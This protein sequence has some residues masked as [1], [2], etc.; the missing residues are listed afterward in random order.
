MTEGTTRASLLTR[1]AATFGV[2]F[3]MLGFSVHAA[4]RFADF[5]VLHLG[6]DLARAARWNDAY[7][8]EAFAAIA[9]ARPEMAA[10]HRELDVFL[11]TPA[12]GWAMW[13]FSA[14]PVQSA[15]IVWIAV[16]V[17]AVAIATRVLSLPLWVVAIA[18]VM[19]FG[20]ANLHHGQTG[21]FA[22]L[23]ATGVH[24]LCVRDRKVL[25]GL[26]AG[27]V[28]LKPTLLLGVAIWWLIDWR[29][30]YPAL[31]AAIPSALLLTLPGLVR[32]GLEPWRL[33]AQ[34][35]SNRI[36]VQSDVVANQPTIRELLKRLLGGDIG[37]HPAMQLLILASGAA[38]MLAL[39][40]RFADRTDVMSGAAVFV[41]ILVSPHLYVYDSGLV[42]I[43]L[44]VLVHHNAD[45]WTTERL[46]A[47]YTMS[48]LL[49][50]MS[51]GFFGTFNEWVA[52]G[53]I[54]ILAM[55]ALWIRTIHRAD[56]SASVR[57][58]RST[59]SSV[60]QVNVTSS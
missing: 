48:S 28:V 26:T 10:S 9:R 6:G 15:L 18:L 45:R 36:D 52:P 12:F 30:W 7:D 27:L 14:L 59:P 38:A 22:I 58:Q 11:S 60:P 50:I 3:F 5:R 31:L 8:P 54:G 53:T 32:D 1:G 16:G 20:V 13:P 42:L 41:S 51:L 56:D 21:F 19:P 4:T 35:S 37:A 40:K 55:F 46:V 39:R 29:R 44:A 24:A 47:I 57:T 23:L 49:T 34:S 25:A 2:V 17:G 43:P 33:F